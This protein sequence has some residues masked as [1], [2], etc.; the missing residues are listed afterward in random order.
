MT[1]GNQLVASSGGSAQGQGLGKVI[2]EGHGIRR[3][4]WHSESAFFSAG[5]AGGVAA[6]ELPIAQRA[7][8]PV[9]LPHPATQLGRRRLK[10]TQPEVIRP[11]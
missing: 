11:I 6:D 4:S 10:G 1:A 9:P 3:G 5:P 8:P 2:G 7:D